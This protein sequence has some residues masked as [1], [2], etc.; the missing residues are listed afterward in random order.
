MHQLQAPEFYHLSLKKQ[1]HWPTPLCLTTHPCKNGRAFLNLKESLENIL[2]AKQMQEFGQVANLF[3]AAQSSIG[4][5]RPPI[6]WVFC[7]LSY[8]VVATESPATRDMAAYTQIIIQ[9]ARGWLAYN[10][11]AQQTG[12]TSATQLTTPPNH[13]L[14]FWF[15]QLQIYK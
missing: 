3:S 15:I 14:L 9:I 11:H 1:S 2:L 6:T 5:T 12:V 8:M 13:A 7:F 10:Q 4:Y